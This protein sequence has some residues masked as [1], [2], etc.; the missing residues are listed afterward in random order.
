M[1]E[2]EQHPELP[3]RNEACAEAAAKLAMKQ[4]LTSG[5]VFVTSNRY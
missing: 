1:T 4:Y 3:D 5:I 2:L